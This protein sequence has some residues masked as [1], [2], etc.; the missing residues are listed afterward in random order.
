MEA[1]K[2]ITHTTTK[3]VN[4]Q[5]NLTHQSN[6]PNGVLRDHQLDS[7]TSTCLLAFQQAE[8]LGSTH[9]VTVFAANRV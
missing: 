2:S 7:K 6:R 1:R 3:Q 4:A 8:L 5:T 9:K